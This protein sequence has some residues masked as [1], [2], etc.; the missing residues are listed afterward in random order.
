MK[1]IFNSLFLTALTGLI[2]CSCEKDLEKTILKTGIPPTL[3]ASNA[4]VVLK[5]ST[6]AD[7]V[8]TFTWNP[9]DYGFSAAVRY[10]LQIAKGGTNFAAPKEIS[11]GAARLFKYTGEEL[12]QLALIQGLAPNS[13]GQLDVRVKSSI[14]DS[15][16]AIYSNKVTISVTP[17]QV[18]INYP[19]L[20]VPG[21]YQGWDPATAPKISSRAANGIYEGYVNIPGG[22]LQ[23]K[24]T[25]DP[26]W[27]HTIYGWASSTTTG[28]DVSGTFNTTGGN[29]F[30]PTTGYHL[31][32][33]N[34]NNNTWSATKITSWS[35]IGDFNNWAADVPMTYNTTTKTWT[36]TI[37]PAAAG[38]F[39]FRANNDWAINYGDT[40]AD[41]I[42]DLNGANIAIT[43]GSHVIT[44]NLSIPGNYTYSIQ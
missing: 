26:D 34:T 4:A 22:T 44:L 43:P 23:F 25:S 5:A 37:N 42:L 29:L 27:N 16:P 33:A 21:D 9:S 31:L 39:K 32:R 8:E 35:L 20:W 15:I 11:M 19:S 41:L 18:I 7:T 24:Y 1:K 2:F 10:T 28:N 3:N 6:A 30:V 40:G 12:N 17:Y 14:S 13:A 36:A 38:G